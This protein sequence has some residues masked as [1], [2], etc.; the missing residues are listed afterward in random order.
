MGGNLVVELANGYKAWFVHDKRHRD[1]GLPAVERADGGKEWW[2]RD[3][4]Y[5]DDGL[6]VV[7]SSDYT[8][9]AWYIT[10]R[11]IGVTVDPQTGAVVKGTVPKG[12]RIDV[13]PVG[14]KAAGRGPASGRRGASGVQH[15]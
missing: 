1:D 8:N 13:P 11:R 5:R 15:S 14:P 4:R 6:P 2:V 10:G 3:Q 9:Q 7:V 12:C